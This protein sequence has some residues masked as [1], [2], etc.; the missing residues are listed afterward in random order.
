MLEALIT[1]KTRI[2]LV[3][4]FFLNPDSRSYLRGL[5]EEFGESSNAI[6]VE[7]NRF[8]KAG[9]LKSESVG[10]KKMFTANT[11]HPLFND[12]QRMVRKTMGIDKIV[13]QLVKKLGDVDEAYITG[14]FARGQNG[15]TI[16]VVLIGDKINKTFLIQLLDKAEKLIE[17][18]IRYL[19]L[20]KKEAKEYLNNIKDKMLIWSI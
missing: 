18:K 11:K 3:L 13:D 12:L 4:K 7:L 15:Q 1:S 16:D 8:E 5:A 17:K 14:A 9:L 2:K 6:R 19:V 10:N 20:N